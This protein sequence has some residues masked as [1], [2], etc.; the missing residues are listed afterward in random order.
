MVAIGGKVA[1]VEDTIRRAVISRL[2]TLDYRVWATV[3]L[4]TDP[5]LVD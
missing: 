3:E 1:L 2:E 4:T 5:A